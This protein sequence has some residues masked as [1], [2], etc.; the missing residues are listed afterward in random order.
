MPIAMSIPALKPAQR[1]R[2]RLTATALAVV[3]LLQ[4]WAMALAQSQTASQAQTPA[5]TPQATGNLP[6]LGDGSGM[7]ISDERRL[8]DS[9]AR[10]L[11]QDPDYLDDPVLVDYLQAIWQPLLAAGR[12]R[13]EVP[14]ELSERLAW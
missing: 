11:Y 2:Q 7:S 5:S 8:G 1:A 4:P 14:P 3:L 10:Q 12:A 6:G 13:G 9:I